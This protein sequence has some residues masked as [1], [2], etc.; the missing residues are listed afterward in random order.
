MLPAAVQINGQAIAV[1]CRKYGVAR[2]SLFGSVLRSDFDSARS[3][4]DVLVDFLPGEHKSLFKLLEMQRALEQLLG[5]KVDLTTRGSLSKY[6]RDDVLASAQVL[7]DA[8]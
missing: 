5:R 7:Y 6:F 1:L 2:L 8:A 4:I 3:D